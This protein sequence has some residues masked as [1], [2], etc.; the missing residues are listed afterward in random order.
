MRGA[1][2]MRERGEVR[3]RERG[4]GVHEKCAVNEGEGVEVRMRGAL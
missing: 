3:M 2:R 4:E 1:L